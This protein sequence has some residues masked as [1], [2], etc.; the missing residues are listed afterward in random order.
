MRFKLDE[1]MPPEAAT[2]LRWAGHDAHTVH[3]ESLSG[4]TDALLFERV[5][6]ESRVLLTMD[7]G[8]ADDRIYGA[9]AH[10]GIIVF[11]LASQSKASVVR[12]IQSI[13]PVLAS[14]SLDGKLWIVDETRVRIRP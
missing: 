13:L 6:T 5:R 3:D 4:A 2:V 14:E 12:A 8:F 7:V 9:S 10:A 11:R 1:N